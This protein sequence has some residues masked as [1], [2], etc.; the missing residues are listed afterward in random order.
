MIENRASSN[1]IYGTVCINVM[2]SRQGKIS[3]KI[4]FPHIC[5]TSQSLSWM[6]LYIFI[7][8]KEKLVHEISITFVLNKILGTLKMSLGEI[9]LVSTTT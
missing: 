9:C 4:G 7:P 1:A 6:L 5:F 3:I 8:V 2:H